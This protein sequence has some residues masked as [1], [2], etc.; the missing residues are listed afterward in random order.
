MK[1]TMAKDM[2]IGMLAARKTASRTKTSAVI[3]SSTT[4]KGLSPRLWG[5]Q[6]GERS[7][8]P[9]LLHLNGLAPEAQDHLL[10]IANQHQHRSQGNSE[11]GNP[12]G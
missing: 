3:F 7:S 6:E 12:H 4:H 11:I 10:N 2:K 8:I 5:P 9:G 1:A